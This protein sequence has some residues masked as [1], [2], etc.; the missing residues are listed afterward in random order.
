MKE[1]AVIEI[2][3]KGKPLPMRGTRWL[4]MDMKDYPLREVPNWEAA[5]FV[6][7]YYRVFEETPCYILDRDTGEC[8]EEI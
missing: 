8:H 5:Q 4:V 1:F 7:A 6:A 2:H 3:R